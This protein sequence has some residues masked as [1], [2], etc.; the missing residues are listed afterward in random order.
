MERML[1]ELVFKIFGRKTQVDESNIIYKKGDER[2]LKLEKGDSV[3]ILKENGKSI[4]IDSG[5]EQLSKADE[6]IC[7]VWCYLANPAF[8]G[9]LKS[10]FSDIVDQVN[11][12][13][14]RDQMTIGRSGKF[15][16]DEVK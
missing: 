15:S 13:K 16:S 5:D 10:M 4:I 7:M 2:I 12:D 3:L 11:A 8:V 6:I 14:A 1:K 9:V